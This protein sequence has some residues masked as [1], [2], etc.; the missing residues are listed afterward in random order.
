MLIRRTNACTRVHVYKVYWYCGQYFSTF[1]LLNSYIPSAILCFC[2]RRSPG[3]S[4]RIDPGKVISTPPQEYN[5][6][7]SPVTETTVRYVAKTDCPGSSL[8][9]AKCL[10]PLCAPD[11][12]GQTASWFR[13]LQENIQLITLTEL[14]SDCPIGIPLSLPD[15]QVWIHVFPP[16]FLTF[17][18]DEL[19][20]PILISAY[21][22]TNQ[23]Y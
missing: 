18:G 14:I 12:G 4:P 23:K 3:G 5:C 7:A 22:Q 2:L 13:D 17:L 8:K 6:V 1:S 9:R 16:R 15:I 10:C 20:V 21:R 19:S 11:I